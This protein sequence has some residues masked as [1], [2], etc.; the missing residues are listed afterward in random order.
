M[1]G[2]VMV[3][4]V[5][6]LTGLERLVPYRRDWQPH[7]SEW[8]RDGLYIVQGAVFGGLAQ[9]LVATAAVMLAPG[10]NGLPLWAA[11]PMAIVLTDLCTYTFH[12]FVHSN[13]WMWREHGV[14]HVTDK[15]NTLN[16]NTAHFLDIFLNNIAALGPLLLLGFSAPALFIASMARAVQTLG[17]HANI[18]VELGWLGHVVMGPEHHRLHH[19]ADADDAG[20]Y[21]TIVTLWDRVFGTFRWSPGRQARVVGVRAPHGFPDAQRI[22]ASALHPFVRGEESCGG[23]SQPGPHHGPEPAPPK[24][25]HCLRGAHR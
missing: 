4:L 2:V 5:V 21:G 11:A 7:G 10:D 15:V 14:H 3:G 24:D 19:S 20:N 1:V 22:W 16:A 25:R 8:T 23:S 17:A 12:R 9:G 18:D 13:D 6:G